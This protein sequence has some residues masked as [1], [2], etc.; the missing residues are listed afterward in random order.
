M[1]SQLTRGECAELCDFIGAWCAENG[2][3]LRK[4]RQWVDPD[5]GEIIGGMQE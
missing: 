1:T 4:A 5:T 3:E 2:V